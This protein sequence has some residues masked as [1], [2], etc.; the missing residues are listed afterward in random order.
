MTDIIVDTI[1]K[2]RNNMQYYVS[3]LA[4]YPAV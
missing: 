1:M 2:Q 4:Y 3:F